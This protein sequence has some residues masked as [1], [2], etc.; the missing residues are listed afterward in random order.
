MCAR[1]AC[2]IVWDCQ[3][4]LNAKIQK[5]TRLN[6]KYGRLFW[7]LAIIACF[8]PFLITSFCFS[9]LGE[10][11]RV[12][13]Y[14]KYVALYQKSVLKCVTTNLFDSFMVSDSCL[15]LWFCYKKLWILLWFCYRFLLNLLWF[16][17]KKLWILLWFYDKHRRLTLCEP[18][19]FKSSVMLWIK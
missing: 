19:L 8:M 10:S 14:K 6:K 17:Y 15:L 16:C 9:T 4:V 1:I 13:I 2:F 5:I 18:F 7:I 3:S 12:C 11:K